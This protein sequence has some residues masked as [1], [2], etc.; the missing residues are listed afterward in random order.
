MEFLT[1]LM[2]KEVSA[3]F[4][5]VAGKFSPRKD[6]SESKEIWV[7]DPI[8]SVFAENMNYAMPRGPHPRWPEISTA[9][10]TAEHEVFTG[11]KDVQTALDEAAATVS[12]ILAQ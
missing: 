8:F 12:A 7:V 11:S 4:C 1:Y 3:D 5:E 9:I 10:S 6:A 2:S